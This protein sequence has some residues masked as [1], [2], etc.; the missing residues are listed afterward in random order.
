MANP[1]I[2]LI[3]DRLNTLSDYNGMFEAAF[4][5]PASVDRVG[6]ALAAYQRSVS[7]GNSPFDRW[8]FGKQDDA[9]SEK[10]KQG[11]RI[12]TGEAGCAS[13]HEIREDWALFTD[14]QFHDTGYGWMREHERQ[15][16]PKTTRVQVAPGV[17]HDVDFAKI[18]AVGLERQSDIGRY[19]VTEEPDDRWKFRTPSLRNVALTPALYA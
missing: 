16:P 17:Y 4:G 5:A 13:C 19:E 3:I 8:Y 7:A 9:L 15:N 14:Q 6:M 10:A 12:F 18:A 11:F 2:G 1:S